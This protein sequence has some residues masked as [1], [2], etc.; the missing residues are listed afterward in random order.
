[1]NSTPRRAQKI[2]VFG[3][4]S[5]GRTSISTRIAE[6]FGMAHIST[7]NLIKDSLG[8]H[9]DKLLANR[10]KD[11]LQSGDMVVDNFINN[12]MKTRLERIDCKSMGFC[13]EGYPRTEN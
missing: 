6:T 1:M 4:P 2:L 5:S 13:L 7:S 8:S 3:A 10:I 9:P 11:K 12:L